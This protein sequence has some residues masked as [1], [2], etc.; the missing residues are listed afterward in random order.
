MSTGTGQE[1]RET[2][3]KLTGN[4]PALIGICAAAAMAAA[5]VT[6]AVA[7]V[8]V[9]EGPLPGDAHVWILRGVLMG[10]AFAYGW[11]AGQRP[12]RIRAEKQLDLVIART[13][14]ALEILRASQPAA[15]LRLVRDE[16]DDA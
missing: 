11:W 7:G 5:G 14:E 12:R 9:G 2:W 10:A 3:R 4:R 8:P 15:P 16:Q 1:P 6:L 13:T